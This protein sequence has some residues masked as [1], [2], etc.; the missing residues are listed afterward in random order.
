MDALC[1]DVFKRIFEGDAYLVCKFGGYLIG[2]A[3]GI[4]ALVGDYGGAALCRY[5]YRHRY[6]APL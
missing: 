6:E 2:Q 5:D 4:V 1:A 3:G